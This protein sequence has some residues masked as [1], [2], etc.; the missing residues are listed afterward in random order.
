MCLG[1]PGQIRSISDYERK[2][3]LVEVS[4]VNR[5]INIACIMPEDGDADSLIDTW[6]LVHVGFAMSRI[7]EKEAA[8]TL[9]LL[10]ELGEVQAE[11]DAMRAA[12]SAM[13]QA[14]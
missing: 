11:I 10:T 1:I 5:E 7:D 14:T 9:E 12:E 4:G 2:L 3:A 6:T 8:L 13:E